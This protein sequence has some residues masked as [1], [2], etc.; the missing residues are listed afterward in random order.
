MDEIQYA[1]IDEAGDYRF[2]FETENVSSHFIIVAILVKE[3]NKVLIE[4]EMEQIK[5]RY[6]QGD[7]IKSNIF[8]TNP[9]LGMQ[10]LHDVRVLPFRVYAYVIDKRKKREDSGILY[11][12]PF[13]KFL[14]RAIYDDLS[15]TFEQLD[16]AADDQETKLFICEFKNYIRTRSI[17]DLFNY[18]TFG[19]NN[20]QSDLLLQLA[21]LMTGILAKGYDKTQLSDYYRS[22]FN[23][24]KNKFAAINLLPLNYTNFLFDFKSE[25]HHSKYDEVIIKQAVN[26]AYKYIEKQRKSEEDDEKL[27]LD[28]LKFL[29]FNLKENP[30]EYV[31]TE[32][33]LD[34]LNAIRD[35]K[36]NPHYFRSN[37]V[38]KLRDSGLLI[39]SSKKGYKLPVCLN[40][41]Y[42]FVN[43]STLTIHP[44]IQRISKCRDQILLATN[45]E[46]DIL[47]QKEYGYLKKVIDM[48]KLEI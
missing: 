41:L 2:D 40:D 17:P 5:Q 4:T 31:Y 3:S 22:F 25:N 27:R 34:N 24:I 28:F 14:N 8:D 18:S 46:V 35:V 11:K 39:A 43:L 7:V 19:F 32:E 42:D 13:L 29:L 1:F 12:T 33:V 44:M 36:I 20:G 6:F 37:I 16:L 38:S 26:L 15:R 21:K 9:T 23:I 45:H 30:D 10:I 47:D 48:E